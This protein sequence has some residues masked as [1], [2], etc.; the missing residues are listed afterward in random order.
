M[1]RVQEKIFKKSKFTAEDKIKNFPKYVSRKYVARFLVQNELF[2][3]QIGI[4]GSIVEC[5]VHQGGGLLTW[6]KLSSIYEPHNYHREVIGF[7]TFEGFPSVSKQKDKSKGAYK[8]N[9][10]EKV[11][12]IKDIE[13]VSKFLDSERS[14]KNKKKIKL[15]KGDANYT[16]PKFIKKNSHILISLLYLDFDIYE[17]TKTA[18]KYFYSR[19][20]KGGII[21]FDELNNSDWPGETLAVLEELNLKKHKIENFYFE[22]NISYIIK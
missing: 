17:P 13:L 2:K 18:L 7:D 9:F 20:P 5:G 1:K 14:I 15:V 6:G 19:I 16:I 21:A 22:P 8:K 11:D 10:S 3:K 12:I 4:K